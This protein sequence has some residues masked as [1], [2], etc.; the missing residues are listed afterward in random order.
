M[1]DPKAGDPLK[2]SPKLHLFPCTAFRTKGLPLAGLP[3]PNPRP[4]KGL[5]E[6]ELPLTLRPKG[7]L[8]AIA[9]RLLELLGVERV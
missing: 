2:L 9:A 7:E 3:P 4:A 5:P 1:V 6:I 8:P